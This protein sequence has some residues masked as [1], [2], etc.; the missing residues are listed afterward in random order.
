[1]AP[2][3][4]LERLPIVFWRKNTRVGAEGKAKQSLGVN[5]PDVGFYSSLVLAQG[6]GVVEKS[7]NAVLVPVVGIEQEFE[8]F[9]E[10][11]T[12]LLPL[13]YQRRTAS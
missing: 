2:K 8:I 1:M 9:S 4:G 3:A 5:Y 6:C 13:N 12:R 7:A 10:S 11:S